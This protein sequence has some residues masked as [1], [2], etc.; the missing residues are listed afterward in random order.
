MINHLSF[1]LHLYIP[2]GS[3]ISQTAKSRYLIELSDCTYL[4]REIMVIAIARLAH[5]FPDLR[6]RLSIHDDFLERSKLYLRGVP[7][8]DEHYHLIVVSDWLF[9]R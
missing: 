3:L 2:R 6:Y 9:V 8:P 1:L 7:S 5:L 4:S